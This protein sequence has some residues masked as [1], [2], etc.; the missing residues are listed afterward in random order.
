MTIATSGINLFEKM[1][2][3]DFPKYNMQAWMSTLRILRDHAELSAKVLGHVP[4][5]ILHE[6]D[7]LQ[8]IAAFQHPRIQGYI[9]MLYDHSQIK[10]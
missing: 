3:S 8:K 6:E 4:D 10:H 7:C 2:Y 1:K 5:N 9:N